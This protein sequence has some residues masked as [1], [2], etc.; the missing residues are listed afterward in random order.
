VDNWGQKAA[1]RHAAVTY[2]DHYVGGLAQAALDIPNTLF[3]FISD[4]GASNTLGPSLKAADNIR[5]DRRPWVLSKAENARC[6][7][8][9][10][11]PWLRYSSNIQ[12][13]HAAYLLTTLHTQHVRAA[14]TSSSLDVASLSARMLP[15]ALQS[16]SV[17]ETK[18]FHR[19]FPLRMLR[20]HHEAG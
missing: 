12:L 16:V 1:S 10:S 19:I 14:S 20:K 4:N 11:Y 8:E 9:D 5:L 15:Y 17:Q 7:L 3:V 13:I 18:L 6:S 2:L